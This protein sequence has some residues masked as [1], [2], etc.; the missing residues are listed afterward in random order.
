MHTDKKKNGER[1]RKVNTIG[2]KTNSLKGGKGQKRG[3]KSFLIFNDYSMEEK[4]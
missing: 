2:D 4:L 3:N 1:D